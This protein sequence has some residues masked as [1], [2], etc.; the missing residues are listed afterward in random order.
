MIAGG[1]P[2]RTVVDTRDPASGV[3]V[4]IFCEPVG[5]EDLIFYQLMR[6]SPFDGWFAAIHKAAAEWDGTDPIR[7]ARPVS[8]AALGAAGGDR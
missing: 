5:V 3:Q 2:L 1:K 8:M 6:P 7:D 4:E